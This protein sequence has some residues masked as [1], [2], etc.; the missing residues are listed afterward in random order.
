MCL[1]NANPNIQILM[2]ARLVHTTVTK[3]VPTLKAPSSVPVTVDIH[4]QVMEDHAM[5][6]MSYDVACEVFFF[7]HCR[8]FQ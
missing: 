7:V 2:N 6:Y 1:I 5:V 3:S 4:C 8:S